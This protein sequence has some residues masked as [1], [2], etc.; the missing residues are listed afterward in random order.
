MFLNKKASMTTKKLIT[1]L[2]VV[3]VVIV[4][5][6]FVFKNPILKY[7]KLIPHPSASDKDFL[8]DYRGETDTLSEKGLEWKKILDEYEKTKCNV[9]DVCK[10][11]NIP[12]ACFTQAGFESQSNFETCSK[13]KPY[14]YDKV[15][16]CSDK[17]PYEKEYY[18]SKCNLAN[19]LFKAIPKCKV[20]S[21]KKII[22]TTPC[23]CHTKE[24]FESSH[25]DSLDFEDR[26]SPELC[27]KGQY[28]YSGDI[29]CSD[30]EK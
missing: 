11:K 15:I 14:C 25:D 6:A 1:I 28:C 8:T 4:V 16:G 3:F 10:A 5:L 30:S 23:F 22:E 21:N 18:S 27:T 12:C 17:N 26:I 13:E 20:D 24:S 19:P 29:G 2:L 7:F 9:D